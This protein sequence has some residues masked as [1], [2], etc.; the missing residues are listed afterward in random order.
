MNG[1][2]PWHGR[3]LATLAAGVAL[4]AAGC[5]G[6]T[7]ASTTRSSDYKKDVAFAHCMRSHGVPDWPDPVPHG[8]FPRTSAGQSPRFGSARG[9]CHHLLPSR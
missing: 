9:A 1:S 6:A 4:L 2:I 7:P 5:G 8:G 3:A